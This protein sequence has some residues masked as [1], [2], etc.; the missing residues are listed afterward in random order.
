[1]NAIIVPPAKQGQSLEAI[2]AEHAGEL[3]VCVHSGYKY[4]VLGAIG[5]TSVDMP[6]KARLLPCKRAGSGGAGRERVPADE[7]TL[8]PYLVTRAVEQQT[9]RGHGAEPRPGGTRCKY[10]SRTAP[11]RC[12]WFFNF[13][14]GGLRRHAPVPGPGRPQTAESARFRLP[15]RSTA[16][17]VVR[18]C[19]SKRN[20]CV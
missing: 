17:A 4:Q 14:P 16:T 18:F 19:G 8:K 7:V 11:G 2:W 20:C 5:L 6:R 9:S 1:M 15:A 13:G 3:P 12:A 10:L